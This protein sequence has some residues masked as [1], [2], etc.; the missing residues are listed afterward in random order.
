MTELANAWVGEG[1]TVTLITLAS[2]SEDAYPL[3]PKIARVALGLTGASPGFFSTLIANWGRLRALRRAIVD[4][5]PDAVIS[6]MTTTNMLVLLALAG[7]RVP[8]VVAERVFVDAHPPPRVWRIL[9]RPLY[10]RASAI[11]SQTSRGAADL[12][13]RVGRAVHVIPNWVLAPEDLAPE[14]QAARPALIAQ[15]HSC[16]L[17]LAI[18]RLEPQKGFDLLIAAFSQVASCHPEWRLLIA[19]EGSARADLARLIV[20]RRMEDRISMPGHLRP[21]RGLMRRADLFV[22]SSRYEGMPNALL[23]SMA[24]GLAC[25]SFDCPTGPSELIEHGVNGLLVPAEDV[26]AMAAALD[27]LMRDQEL[28]TRLGVRARAVCSNYS[29]R[30][31]MDQWNALLD[32]VLHERAGVERKR[33]AS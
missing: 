17:V 6:F 27:T 4:C 10:R 20:A 18:G 16:R 19:G 2:R 24:V 31:I 26:A 7:L 12:E 32:S 11:V 1:A 5:R 23:E 30:G 25:A 14:P 28:R 21:L 15:D 8:V 33:N 13:L 9:Y 29:Q 22:L 3:H